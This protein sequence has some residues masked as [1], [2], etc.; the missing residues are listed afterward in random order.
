MKYVEKKLVQGNANEVRRCW[1]KTFVGAVAG[2]AFLIA[3]L[4]PTVAKADSTPTNTASTAGSSAK[5][6]VCHKG[7]TLTI[8]RNALDAHLA[9]GDTIGACVVTTVN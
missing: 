3:P 2:A 8:S 1:A 9:H 6:T 5:V 7:V 4:G